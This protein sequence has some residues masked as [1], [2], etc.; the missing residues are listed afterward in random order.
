[1]TDGQRRMPYI[2][3]DGR[4]PDRDQ[5]AG[6]V[7]SGYGHFTAMQVRN[8]AVQGLPLHIG[9]LSTANRELF[10]EALDGDH[11]RSLIRHALGEIAD[12]SVR[13]LVQSPD[14]TRPPTLTVVVR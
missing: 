7:L 1:M 4:E 3:V 14:P 2:E 10:G 5:L 13:V 6:L 8:Q 12:A 9:R 11:I